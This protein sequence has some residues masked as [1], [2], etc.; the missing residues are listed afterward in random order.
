M[1][2]NS[3]AWIQSSFV[4]PSHQGRGECPRDWLGRLWS[5]A[6]AAGE[7][8]RFRHERRR[9]VAERCGGSCVGWNGTGTTWL[10][11]LAVTELYVRVIGE[12][13]G[14]RAENGLPNS[15]I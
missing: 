1:D 6:R 11:H 3:V 4:V 5:T 13:V 15:D 7:G 14:I 2:T 10:L 9:D 8:G 12:A